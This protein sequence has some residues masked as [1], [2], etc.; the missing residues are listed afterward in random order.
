MTNDKDEDFISPEPD[1]YG[2]YNQHK[3]SFKSEVKRLWDWK[4]NIIRTYPIW[5]AYAAWCEGLIIGI[6]VMFFWF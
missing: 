1:G 4:I 5:C 6:L 2:Q 3:K